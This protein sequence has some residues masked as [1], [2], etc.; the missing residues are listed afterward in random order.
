MW[1]KKDTGT[2]EETTHIKALLE[3]HHS[4]LCSA[5]GASWYLY[6]KMPTI[7]QT[8]ASN[9]PKGRLIPMIE[10]AMG[11][12]DTSSLS[13]LEESVIPSLLYRSW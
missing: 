10:A 3:G 9:L 5:Y 7:D 8:S 6:V 13:T 12:K 4:R 1:K 11:V 2:W